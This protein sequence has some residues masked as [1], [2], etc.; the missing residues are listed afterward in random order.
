[1]KNQILLDPQEIRALATGDVLS[2]EVGGHTIQVRADLPQRAPPLYTAGGRQPLARARKRGRC[3]YCKS[4]EHT[5]QECQKYLAYH[6]RLTT[7]KRRPGPSRCSHCLRSFPTARSLGIHKRGAHGILGIKARRTRIKKQGLASLSLR[8]RRE[9]ASL[10]GQA[11]ARQMR[12][13]RT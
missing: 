7:S 10:G 2:F 9:I 1:M 4:T 5:T 3:S 12:R 8:R 11:R 13:R 6:H